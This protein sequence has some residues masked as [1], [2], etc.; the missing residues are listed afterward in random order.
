MKCCFVGHRDAFG[1]EDL[2]YAAIR[3]LINN[4]ITDFYSGGMGNFDKMCESAVRHAGGTLTFVPY[5]ESQV[6][7]NDKL[8]YDNIVCPFGKKTYSIYD[9]PNRNKWVV[10]NCDVVLCYVYKMGG[11]MKTLDYAV[12]ERKIIVNL[13]N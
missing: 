12:R 9:I 13:Y 7:E 10:D 1:I 2:V 3:R 4:G 8:W 5:N 11:A 6:K